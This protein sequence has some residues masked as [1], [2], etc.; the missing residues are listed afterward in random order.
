MKNT[1][2]L[3]SE[4]EKNINKL[5][6]NK[7]DGE[8]KINISTTPKQEDAYSR[9]VGKKIYAETV[10]KYFTGFL[11]ENLDN[12]IVVSKVAWI[13][14][15]GRFHQGITSGQFNEVEPYGADDIVYLSKGGIM[16]IKEHNFELP[17]TQK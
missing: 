7:Q 12:E 15:T 16:N 3:L 13:A 5:I 4:L 2:E 1:T 6:N 10:T 14:D 9:L 8:I 17:R 11:E